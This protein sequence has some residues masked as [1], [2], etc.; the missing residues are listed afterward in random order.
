[1]GSLSKPINSYYRVIIKQKENNKKNNIIIDNKSKPDSEA[2]KE[3]KTTTY[4]YQNKLK[5]VLHI[6]SFE[7]AIPS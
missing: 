2:Y 6:G 1:M 4:I 3:D 7:T 5:S